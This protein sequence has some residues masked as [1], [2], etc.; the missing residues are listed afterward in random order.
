MRAKHK[1][2][3]PSH[4]GKRTF[5]WILNPLNQAHY[6]YLHGLR[7]QAQAIE[8]AHTQVKDQMSIYTAL[9]NAI[10][11]GIFSYTIV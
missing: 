1:S 11:N 7:S 3:Q 5:K 4:V 2:F 6:F 8:L 10:I 9:G